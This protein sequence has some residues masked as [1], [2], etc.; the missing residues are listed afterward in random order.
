VLKLKDV[1]CSCIS[2]KGVGFEHAEKL[3]DERCVYRKK[4]KKYMWLGR[5]GLINALE[6]FIRLVS[7]IRQ[8]AEEFRSR[9]EIL[10]G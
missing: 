9:R 8:I 6:F 4:K 7:P 2:K 1:R 5:T 10:H 3:K